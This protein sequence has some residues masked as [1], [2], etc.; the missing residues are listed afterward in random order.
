MEWVPTSGGRLPQGRRPVEG[1][2]EQNGG[3]L[4]HAYANIQGVNV[5]GKTGEHLV[6]RCLERDVSCVDL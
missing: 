3:Q 4:Y 1:G 2:Y 6:R 5:P